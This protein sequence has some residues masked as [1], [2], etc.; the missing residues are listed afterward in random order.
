MLPDFQQE[1]YE[2]RTITISSLG[3]VNHEYMIIDESK[4]S[5]LLGQPLNRIKGNKSVRA[6]GKVN[7]AILYR[8]KLRPK[9]WAIT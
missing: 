1:I 2:S 5:I 3:M 7:L 8:N 6:S 4:D 9:K